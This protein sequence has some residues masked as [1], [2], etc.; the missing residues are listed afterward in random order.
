ML[1]RCKAIGLLVAAGALGGCTH[2]AGAKIESEPP[3]AEVVYVDTGAVLGMTPFHYWWETTSSDKRFINV[4][5]QKPG[6]QDKTTGFYISPR[7]NTH[8]E[9]LRDPH[10][11]K[12][13]LEKSN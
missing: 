3:G 7:H 4:R 1:N 11:V 13:N 12:V 10:E 2:Y 8:V 5:F 6:Y 9:A